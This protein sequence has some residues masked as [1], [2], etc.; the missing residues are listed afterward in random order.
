MF[1][2]QQQD[3]QQILF[4]DLWA[5]LAVNKIPFPIAIVSWKWIKLITLIPK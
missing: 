2:C 4:Y 3:H 1:T 5:L